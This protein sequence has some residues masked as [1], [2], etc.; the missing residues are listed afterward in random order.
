MDTN[1]EVLSLTLLIKFWSCLSVF[2]RLHLRGADVSQIRLP[3]HGCGTTLSLDSSWQIRCGLLTFTF[4]KART[5][6][7]QTSRK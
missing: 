7:V 3:Y 6:E 2:V 4:I 1:I 5:Q